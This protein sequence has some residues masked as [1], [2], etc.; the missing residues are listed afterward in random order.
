[1]EIMAICPSDSL[2]AVIAGLTTELNNQTTVTV[3]KIVDVPRMT[4][5]AWIAIIFSC[6]VIV[7]IV[8]RVYL[9]IQSGGVT[10]KI[11]NLFS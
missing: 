10:G 1:M 4:K 3:E 8:M 9:R 6:C 5:I 2:E 11:K 7:Y